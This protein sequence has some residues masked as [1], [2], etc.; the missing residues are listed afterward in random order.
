MSYYGGAMVY[1]VMVVLAIFCIMLQRHSLLG[2][3]LGF[4]VFSLVLFYIFV[5]VFG[6]MQKSV[7]LSLVFL[8]LEVCVMSVCLGLMVKLVGVSGSD[9]VGACSL[10]DNF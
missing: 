10:S 9:Y 5:G 1:S 2:I 3:L 6:A 4:E 8:C 7:G